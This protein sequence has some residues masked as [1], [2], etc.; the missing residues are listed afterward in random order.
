[1]IKAYPLAFHF[2]GDH[3]WRAANSKFRD[4]LAS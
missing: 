2:S 4:Y 3:P 1:M